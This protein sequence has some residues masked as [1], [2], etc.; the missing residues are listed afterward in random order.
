MKIIIN[1][2]AFL[3]I[4]CILFGACQCEDNPLG[5]AFPN[6]DPVEKDNAEVG[7]FCCNMLEWCKMLII[8]DFDDIE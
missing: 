3:F 5:E 7:K 6:C 2:L 4:G 8:N 1:F